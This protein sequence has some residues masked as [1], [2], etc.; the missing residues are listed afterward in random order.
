[1]IQRFNSTQMCQKN[2]PTYGSNRS[3]SYFCVLDQPYNHIYMVT[4]HQAVL[5]LIATQEIRWRYHLTPIYPPI[6]YHEMITNPEV[7]TV[8]GLFSSQWEILH[9]MT[10][11]EPICTSPPTGNGGQQN[12]PL[13]GHHMASDHRTHTYLHSLQR[14]YA[15]LST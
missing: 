5:S 7:P 15:V 1:M 8:L 11:G 3:V 14:E 13:I 10:V 4:Q 2:S 12:G 6:L 9:Y